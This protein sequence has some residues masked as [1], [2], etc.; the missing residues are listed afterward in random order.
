MRDIIDTPPSGDTSPSAPPFNPQKLAGAAVDMAKTFDFR[1]Y[2]YL[3]ARRLWIL[4]VCFAGAVGIM[5]FNMARQEPTFQAEARIQLT[6]PG[7]IPANL[8]P[9]EKESVLGDY[10]YTQRQLILS[11]P[12]IT[13]AKEKLGLSPAEFGQR[14]SG[15][16]VQPLWQTAIL[17][18]R[19]SGT[20]PQFCADY[21]NAVA[22]AFVEYKSS[23]RADSSQGTIV[24]LSQQADRLSSELTKMENDVLA[25]VRD[26]SVVGIE[27]RGNV[28]AEL[29]GNLSK[30]SA[31]FKTQR[32]LLEAQQP[33]LAQASDDAILT[34]LG[35]GI[36]LPPAPENGPTPPADGNTP[37][38]LEDSAE[39]LIEHGIVQQ[40][41]W[42]GLKRENAVLEAQLATYR[43][44]YKDAH[45]IIQETLRKLQEN[46]DALK[47]ETQ[48]ALK[49]YYSQLEALT[50]KER[51]AKRVEQA[52]EEEALQIDRKQ[53]EYESLMRNLK[54]S[55]G[56]YD[57][58]FNRLKEID[59]STGIQLESV[60]IIE[61]A[62]VPSS[63]VN[64]Q[65]M[66]SL[67]LAAIIGLA[68]GIGIIFLLD[69]MDDSIRYPEE[70]ARILGAPFLG[71]IPTANWPKTDE[72]SYLI[73]NVDATSGFAE[74][75]RNVR[76]AILLN[77][78]GKS[79]KTLC[80]TSAVPQ[81][82]KTTTSVNLAI[83]FAQAGN[84]VLL[85]DADLHRGELH[86]RF[87]VNA[88]WGLTDILRGTRTAEEV[89]QQIA[90][91]PH[92]D[93]IGTGAFPENAA[94]LVMQPTMSKFLKEAEKRYDLV[95]L[96][97]PPVMVISES[98]VLASLADAVLFVVW[99][100]RTSRKLVQT[101]VRQ[102]LARGAN[103]LGVILNNLDLS[104]MSNYGYSS[105]YHYYGYDYRYAS[106]RSSNPPKAAPADGKKS[107]GA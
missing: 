54:R 105:Y 1:R 9:K 7:G 83:C 88:G 65:N 31:E 95:I 84:K 73:H 21:A 96:D 60:R 68:L 44:K 63:P 87:H 75:Y 42:Y 69:F 76:S 81:E 56:L 2:V 33:L 82:G 64:P 80:L 53:K 61:R 3:I 34:T 100:G 19:V 62:L 26:N 52:W 13:L 5:L 70:A 16:D 103:I 45:P 102:L 66:Q 48:F 24:N 23:E 38:A 29:L 71:L 94:E 55:Q 37:G 4:L 40:A 49:Q 77:P 39:N 78:A 51:A 6:Q 18:I 27:E 93:F 67:F 14:Y 35:Y 86:Q 50:I 97:A 89:T 41:N 104:R 57:L 59:I 47:V 10:L 22:D 17:Y 98:T 20:E 74:A 43:K 28:A 11:R 72:S 101:S 30:Q 79:L 12:V 25:F 85:V 90:E 8:L 46:E 106:N 58:I 107:E 92:L 32:M 91:V 36:S 15:L 99:S